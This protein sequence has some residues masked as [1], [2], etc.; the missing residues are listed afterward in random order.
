MYSYGNLQTNSP[1]PAFTISL[2]VV[3]KE[4]L[5]GHIFIMQQCFKTFLTSLFIWETSS[6]SFQNL[7]K[8]IANHEIYF[9]D[10]GWYCSCLEL[11]KQFRKIHLINYISVCCGSSN[12][13]WLSQIS[14]WF[15]IFVKSTLH[16]ILNVSIISQQSLATPVFQRQAYGWI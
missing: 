2:L 1:N 14:C 11:M 6:P 12:A 4:L 3:K 5:A 9:S 16:R 10:S 8:S 13:S 7:W 15:E